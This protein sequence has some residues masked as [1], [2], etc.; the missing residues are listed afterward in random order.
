MAY[1]LADGATVVAYPYETNQLRADNPETSFSAELPD[2][3]LADWGVYPVVPADAPSTAP[4]EVAEEAAP[5][6][7]DGAWTQQWVVR[8][9]T[10]E[11]L[12]GAKA[13]K[14]A[15][16]TD[17]RDAVLQSGWTHDFGEAGTHTLDL[18]NADDKVNWTLLLIETQ[19]M[20]AAGG[21]DTPV[22]IRTAANVSIF[23]T[24]S[25]ANAAMVSFLGWGKA[26]LAYKWAL[27]EAIQSAADFAALDAIDIGAGW[28]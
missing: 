25:V 15:A 20:I 7:V 9:R 11:E 14:R 24:A 1:I 13:A 23:V 22:E 12:D 8:D 19:G 4:G 21:G 28:P 5:A 26:A 2:E 27:D 18:R 6:L 17:Q 10:D 16:L 3:R